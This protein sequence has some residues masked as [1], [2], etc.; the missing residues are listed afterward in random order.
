MNETISFPVFNQL[1]I[2]GY[3]LYESEDKE[4]FV[5]NFKDGPN[6]LIGVNGLGKSTLITILFRMLTGPYDLNRRALEGELGQPDVTPVLLSDR[7]IFA[8]RVADQAVAARAVLNFT[9]GGQKVV[10]ERR[11]SDLSLLRMVVDDDALPVGEDD[12]DFYQHHLAR[13]MKAGNFFD[14]L[15]ILRF[16]VFVFED[17]R[18]LIW[19]ESA[20]RQIFRAIL[21]E[22]PEAAVLSLSLQR[23]VLEA[24]SAARNIR[25]QLNKARRQLDDAIKSLQTRDSS[26][27]ELFVTERMAIAV[28]EK[29]AS[30][31][32]ALDDLEVEW[33]QERRDRMRAEHE[34]D[35][36]LSSLDGAKLRLITRKFKDLA[37]AGRLAL[38]RIVEQ[39]ICACCGQEADALAAKIES[40]VV[41]DRCAYCEQLLPTTPDVN[42]QD[43]DRPRIEALSKSYRL[44]SEQANAST[45]RLAELDEEKRT[46]IL[47]IQTVERELNSILTK[48]HNLRRSASLEPDDVTRRRMAVDSLSEM[49][50][51]HLDDQRDAERSLQTLVEQLEKSVRDQQDSIASQFAR[52]ASAFMR[53]TCHLT[54][55]GKD[56]RI[57]Q[58]GARFR[59][60]GFQIALSG[61][62]VAGETLRSSP[63]AVSLSQREFIDIAFR[64]AVLEIA[65]RGQGSSLIVDTPEAG[66]DFL[67]AERAGHQFRE[68]A[69]ETGTRNRVVVTSNLVSDHLLNA[70]FTGVPKGVARSERLVNLLEHAAP[71]A[72]VRM[73]A[74]RYNAFVSQIVGIE[75]KNAD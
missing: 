54:Y 58:E 45:K 52:F 34:R 18:S 32:R 15:L 22:T 21:S 12:R 75:E 44:A 2:T 64:M 73:D 33:L 39:R 30:I 47:E 27:A 72:A 1:E 53:E 6:A 43:L 65:S 20:Q 42:V 37:P 55:I 49:M 24:D 19:D 46:R 68:F 23:R 8:R 11:L 57:G 10:I 25:V 38:S 70:L 50:N 26:Q 66:L 69:P 56:E 63:D 17:R 3:S 48:Q 36:I 40:A 16:L 60:P 29:R 71:T 67:F 62:A 31:R 61:G 35:K 59:F 5:W 9:I 51:D 14:V 4:T 74:S 41:E 7:R 13:L 28:D